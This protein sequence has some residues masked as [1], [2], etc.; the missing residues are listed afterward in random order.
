MSE[1]VAGRLAGKVCVI[2][3][4]GGSMGRA[5]ALRFAE[6]GALVVGC[7]VAVAPA[8]ETVELVR[9]AGGAMVS[10]Q[11]CTLSDPEECVRLVDF[12]VKECGRIDVLF[13]LA[14]RNRFAWLEEV[15][16]EDWDG[17]RRDEVDLVF[18]LTRAAWPHLRASRGA[19]V[20]MAS[21]N[22]SIGFKE[23]PS[24]SHTTNKAAVI[25]MTRQLALEGGEHGIRVNSLSPG[26][27]ETGATRA[28]L[29]EGDFAVRMAARTL[30]GRPGRPEEVAEVALF[31]AGDESSYVTGVDLVVDGGMKVW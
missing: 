19:V 27:I 31:L 18:Y 26:L 29:A 12:A 25:G 3:G 8:E 4:T 21:L 1:R 20:N 30:L 9:A 23:L 17:A 28:Q 24:L 6:E 13:N 10:L 7:D 11:P 16:D 5:A 15:T 14:A 2:T 22:G